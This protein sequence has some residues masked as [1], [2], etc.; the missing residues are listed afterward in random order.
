MINSGSFVCPPLGDDPQAFRLLKLHPGH[1]RE[2]VVCTVTTASLTE[3]PSFTA[4][5][6][7]WGS[8][9]GD[10]EVLCNGKHVAISPNLLSAL[11]HIRDAQTERIF[12]CDHLCIDQHDMEDKVRQIPLMR[13]IYS[14]ATNVI[15]WLGPADNDTAVAFELADFMTNVRRLHVEREEPLYFYSQREFEADG[16]SDY[17]IPQRLMAGGRALADL[18]NRP[19]FYRVWV[20]QEIALARK[21]TIQCGRS[22]RDWDMFLDGIFQADRTDILGLEEH[23]NITHRIRRLAFERRLHQS[24]VTIS[25]LTL[26][27]KYAA[28]NATET[29]D[30]VYALLGLASDAGPRG[31]NIIPDYVSGYAAVYQDLALKM[32]LQPHQPLDILSVPRSGYEEGLP[33]WVPDWSENGASA[34]VGFR[35]HNLDGG[36]LIE[37]AA[38]PV[39]AAVEVAVAAQRPN[40]IGLNGHFIDVVTN[41]GRPFH[42]SWPGWN[43]TRWTRWS[44]WLKQLAI[45]ASWRE[46]CRVDDFPNGIYTQTNDPLQEVFWF[47]SIASRVMPAG[48][49]TTRDA[50][51]EFH[52]QTCDIQRVALRPW[53][54]LLLTPW[55][56]VSAVWQ[57]WRF[58]QWSDL[59]FIF[60]R[61]MLFMVARR[62]FRTR[63]GLVGL[64]PE[65]MKPGD[66]IALVQR[67]ATPL[68]LRT[69][70]AGTGDLKAAYELVGDAYVHGIMRG[71][72]FDQE[73]CY[74]IWIA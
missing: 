11:R 4:L 51:T 66:E 72:M 44:H 35:E 30:K 54:T 18:V 3:E 60:R 14:T 59:Q 52:A 7:C 24:G 27:M 9:N 70:A 29:E 37:F 21:V 45:F 53:R 48:L 2:V 13:T 22:Y 50:H 5:S 20:V 33:T 10:A 32:L 12:W 64:G 65:H 58:N 39:N 74:E 28:F 31:L 73:R 26:L 68:V 40:E 43:P 16:R 42:D 63:R 6:Y 69:T 49:D 25:L 34:A 17:I 1:G 15:A 62:M 67:S 55:R 56:V 57:A 36:Y 46:I 38:A 47:T 41:V 71:E 8:M 19:F 23:A 61:S